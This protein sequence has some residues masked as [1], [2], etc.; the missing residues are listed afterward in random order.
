MPMDG[1]A[2]HGMAWH[3]MREDRRA[4]GGGGDTDVLRA[5]ET[6]SSLEVCGGVGRARVSWRAGPR[7]V[8]EE[9]TKTPCKKAPDSGPVPAWISG[10]VYRQS[11]GA[12]LDDA[13]TAFLDGLAHISAYHFDNGAVTYSNKF[14]RTAMYDTFVK[15]GRRTWGGTATAPS[16]GPSM[17]E[18]TWQKIKALFGS[19]SGP[20]YSSF[21]PNVNTVLL[22][23]GTGAGGLRLAASTE[24]DGTAC[25]FD[26]VTLDT[27]GAAPR[28]AKTKDTV[29]TTAAHYFVDPETH[30]GF[31]VSLDLDWHMSGVKPK[32]TFS[33]VL[34]HGA[35]PPYREVGRHELTTFRW[36]EADRCSVKERAAYMHSMA[37][38]ENYVVL[39][40]SSKRV[41]YEQLLKRD[42]SRGFFGLFQSVETPLEFMVFRIKDKRSLALEY[43]DTIACPA[44][45]CYMVW[46]LANCFEDDEGCIVIDAAASKNAKH[47][48][49]D[50]LVMKEPHTV[51][52]FRINLVA[53]T[54]HVR[55]LCSGS[56]QQYEFPNI[57][58]RFHMKP[59]RH[60]FALEFPLVPGAGIVHIKRDAPP[61][62]APRR[63][64]G[65]KSTEIAGEPVFVPR[66]G[67]TD[68]LDGVVL[69]EVLDVEK[70]SSRLL[71]CVATEENFRV[72]ASIEA[73]IPG[74][75]G[76]HSTWVDHAST[77]LAAK[78]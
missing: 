42:F 36:G 78:F 27:L 8:E 18:Q 15:T 30:G 25:E 46:H 52:N 13:P 58:P 7:D 38:T 47:D 62:E 41:C 75:I 5:A 64:E 65:F 69:V 24:N 73:P 43:V 35:S 60:I 72:E 63:L 10:S 1:M 3:G 51:M 54:A 39:F 22:S 20:V 32:F 57:N 70:N 49:S 67:S 19:S 56:P 76:L 33:Y 16:T 53:R 21:N 29:I 31:H 44:P 50:A 37:Q 61:H 9:H 17:I 34:W 14:M 59:N 66:P 77:Q 23:D 74:N 71:I 28:L 68:E 26:P 48:A 6:S 2:W 55:E 12:F 40:L 45:D 11:G 4:D